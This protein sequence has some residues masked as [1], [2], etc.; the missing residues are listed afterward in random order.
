MTASDTG[1]V[2]PF[3]TQPGEIYCSALSQQAAA[4]LTVLAGLRRFAA[5]PP[6]TGLWAA[7]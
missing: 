7:V 2:I 6:G 4:Q 3:R 1:V 5:N